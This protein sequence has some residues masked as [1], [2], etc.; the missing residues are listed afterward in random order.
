MSA[1]V[2]FAISSATRA[3]TGSF[4][5]R[6]AAAAAAQE[7]TAS[8][9]IV[10]GTH[11]RTLQ[12]CRRWMCPRFKESGAADAHPVERTKR[13]RAARQRAKAIQP[14][15][16][17]APRSHASAQR[18]V[19]VA[20][21]VRSHRQKQAGETRPRLPDRGAQR[22]EIEHACIVAGQRQPPHRSAAATRGSP[23]EIAASPIT[24]PP[25][26]MGSWHQRAPAVSRRE[27]TATLRRDIGSAVQPSIVF[28]GRQT[29]RRPTLAGAAARAHRAC[30]PR[31]HVACVR[32]PR[33]PRRGAVAHARP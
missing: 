13:V 20:R 29:I 12:Y 3:S 30:Q 19:N 23:H 1:S 15:R 14:L 27:A 17:A 11:E 10:L 4:G 32:A 8:A 2:M 21:R 9:R 25:I 18:S 28:C 31:V 6:A 5:P 26:T 22:Q 24:A 16:G 33:R 7:A